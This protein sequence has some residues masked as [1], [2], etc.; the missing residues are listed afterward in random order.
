[1]HKFEKNHEFLEVMKPGSEQIFYI[2]FYLCTQS[3][4]HIVYLVY[5]NIYKYVTFINML[6]FSLNRLTVCRSEG[7][8]S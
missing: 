6:I 5:A 3:S 2:K 1:M 4:N 7:V 8:C